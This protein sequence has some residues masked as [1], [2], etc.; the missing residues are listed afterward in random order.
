MTEADLAHPPRRNKA[1]LVRVLGLLPLHR[2]M[3]ELVRALGLL[4]LRRSTAK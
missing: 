2:S 3:A 4:P 1:E